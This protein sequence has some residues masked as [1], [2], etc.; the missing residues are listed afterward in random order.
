MAKKR[1]NNEGS[2]YRRSN[3]SWRAMVTLQGERLT[4]SAKTKRQCQEW[5][6][7]TLEEVENGLT[8]DSTQVTLAKFMDDWLVSIEPSLR[9]NTFR[10]YQQV[11]KQYI[12]PALEEHRLRELKPEHIQQLYN[13]MV[14]QGFGLR[15]IQLTHAVIH[16]AL[17]HAIRLGLISRNPD[18]ATTPPRP[19]RK[20]MQFLDENQVQQ[21]LIT[22]KARNDRLYA[23]YY[24]A[25]AT[26]MRQGEL[27]GLK[28]ADLDWEQSALQVHRQLTKKKGGGREFTLPKTK[29]GIRRIDLGKEGLQVLKEHQQKQYMS[30][31]AAGNKWQ[32][33]ELVFP[34]SIGTPMYGEYLIKR[35][36]LILNEARLPDIRFHDLRHTAASLMLN[37]GIPV[38]IVS[39]RLGHS[40][41]SIT[42]DVYGHLIPGKQRE[43]ASLMDQL[44]TPIQI[45]IPK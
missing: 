25:I 23:L 11:T 33:Q 19:K 24:M 12:L 40:R 42:L 31:V 1:G 15:T 21:L 16:R 22:A 29:A 18:D 43:A 32:D 2:I 13:G 41:P 37:N 28:W 36:K 3:G 38:I 9:F 30:M 35:F 7:Q 27:L 10:Q 26:G 44:L 6:R 17:A 4:Y 14:R 8:Y 20:E 34:T 45:E 5:L 39:R